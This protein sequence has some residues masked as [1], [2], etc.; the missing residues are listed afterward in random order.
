MKLYEFYFANEKLECTEHEVKET[1]KQYTVLKRYIRYNALSRISKELIGKA[2]DD[3]YNT[4]SC[5]LLENNIETATKIFIKYWENNKIPKCETQI[6][7][8]NDKLEK[9]KNELNYLKTLT[10]Q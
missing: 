10:N 3:G 8:A 2:L 1:P 6:K 4:I 7:H 5:L 9:A